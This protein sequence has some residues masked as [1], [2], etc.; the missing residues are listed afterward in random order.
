MQGEETGTAG[1]RSSPYP[2]HL[3]DIGTAQPS[4]ALEY[5]ESLIL[6]EETKQGPYC[7]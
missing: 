1:S 2:S 7:P 4:K 6:L 5:F 3:T